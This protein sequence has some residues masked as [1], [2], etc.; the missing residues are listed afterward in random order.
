M[1]TEGIFREKAGDRAGREG[2]GGA[3][4]AGISWEKILECLKV[5][6]KNRRGGS[7]GQ[8]K[9]CGGGL[10]GQGGGRFHACPRLW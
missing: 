1:N 4:K 8:N 3:Q 6:G 2:G 10:M 9:G 7:Q 5:G